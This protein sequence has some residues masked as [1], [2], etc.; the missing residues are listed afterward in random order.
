MSLSYSSYDALAALASAFH[1]AVGS[2]HRASW[3]SPVEFSSHALIGIAAA[4]C[5]NLVISIALNVQRYAHLR[6]QHQA[7]AAQ[8]REYR[9]SQPPGKKLP[10]HP[11]SSADGDSICNSSSAPPA[12]K[13]DSILL[14]HAQQLNATLKFSASDTSAGAA[15]VAQHPSHVLLAPNPRMSSTSY[16][17]PLPEAPDNDKSSS[18]SSSSSSDHTAA[19]E[20]SHSDKEEVA[21]AQSAVAEPAQM[22]PIDLLTHNHTETYH[23]RFA[24]INDDDGSETSDSYTEP[25]YLRSS[26]WWL[27]ALLMTIGETGNFIAYGFAPAS[28]VSPLGVLALVSNCIIAPIFFHERV[29]ARN[30]AGVAV[31]V[32]GILLIVTSVTPAHVNTA[33]AIT[34]TQPDPQSPRDAIVGAVTRLA[35]KIYLTIVAGLIA[36]FLL[37]GSKPVRTAWLHKQEERDAPLLQSTDSQRSMSTVSSINSVFALPAS[38]LFDLFTNLG[39]V[40]LFGALTA[41]STK[42]LS[43]LLSFSFASTLV[44]P[45]AYLLLLVLVSTA[46]FQVIFLNRALQRYR[47]TIV[48]PVHFVFFTISVITGSAVTFRDFENSTRDELARFGVG[49]VLTFIGVW[50]ITSTPAD[51]CEP[52]ENQETEEEANDELERGIGTPRLF[53]QNYSM[54]PQA[55]QNLV[56]LH[57]HVQQNPDPSVLSPLL[58]PSWSTHSRRQSTATVRSL[59][60]VSSASSAG[61]RLG[62]SV[63]VAAGTSTPRGFGSAVETPRTGTPY[64]SMA[65]TPE[66]RPQEDDL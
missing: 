61:G 33:T 38:P 56:H 63:V 66:L 64:G 54:D 6:L 39:L 55:Q 13:P 23:A 48:I 25:N 14:A 8:A 12:L 40:A 32:A 19:L 22:P 10:S 16:M 41:L 30:L 60:K 59:Y 1:S 51:D 24:D 28:V 46:V 11:D 65:S 5:G 47:A 26:L 18:S 17:P 43:S 20:T 9:T 31:A 34:T 57:R 3:D 21:K 15:V 29:A 2:I 53:V 42:A 52:Q 45:F 4:V 62:S 36:L 27:G 35:F 49:C 7:A 44:D 37:I 58:L 50:L